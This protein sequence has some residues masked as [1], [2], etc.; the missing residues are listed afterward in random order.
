MSTFHALPTSL[1]LEKPW[2]PV[3]SRR[4]ELE[5]VTGAVAAEK[6][7]KAGLYQLVET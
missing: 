2:F 4:I 3:M 5:T 7:T 6:G 1:T